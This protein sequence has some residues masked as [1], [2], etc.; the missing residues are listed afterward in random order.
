[1]YSALGY[2]KADTILAALAIAIGC[3]AC[4]QYLI[5]NALML[6]LIIDRGFSGITESESGVQ[7]S[8]PPQA[9]R[10]AH[11]ALRRILRALNQYRNKCNWT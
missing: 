10:S 6:K 7:A 4:V 1:M 5:L 3:P 2:G 9:S 8:V 11:L